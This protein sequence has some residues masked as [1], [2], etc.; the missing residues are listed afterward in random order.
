MNH[1]R[2]I[3]ITPFLCA[4]L[5][6]TIMLVGACQT[7]VRVPGERQHE[8]TRTT[9]T[10]FMKG[11]N[12][13]DNFPDYTSPQCVMLT[14]ELR[15]SGLNWVAITPCGSISSPTSTDVYW[16]S[17]ASRDYKNAIQ[18]ARAESMNVFLKPYL[19]S[20][21]FFRN[22]TWTGSIRFED[23]A[24]IE[25]WFESYTSFIVDN[26]RFAEAGGAEMLAVGMELPGMTFHT[27]KWRRLIDTVRNHYS[28]LLTYCA[29]GASEAARI[30]FWDELDVVCVNVYPTLSEQHD[31][32]DSVLVEG[33]EAVLPELRSL[34]NTLNKQIVLSELGFRSVERAAYKPWEWAEHS[35][36]TAN[37]EA[38][39]RAYAA[40]ATALY[41]ESWLGG[42]FWWKVFTSPPPDPHTDVSFTPQNKPAF[43]QMI[44]DFR[45][46]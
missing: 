41:D 10:V 45:R 35:D 1:V 27:S 18:L 37:A 6:L 9:P 28:G 31:P 23:S 32:H 16:S 46:R 2:T 15:D 36:R 38:Q 20:G 7:D 17:W 24:D 29:H 42:V 12:I 13:A 44:R 26:A 8:L 19:F 3:L 22:G 40:T 33:W 25:R 5:A 43:E 21:D 34:S 14:R 4:C 39:R 11:V 30:E